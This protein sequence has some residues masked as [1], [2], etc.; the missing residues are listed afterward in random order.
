MH[1]R[2]GP[3][4]GA[5]V[6]STTRWLLSVSL[7]HRYMFYC[8]EKWRSKACDRGRIEQ[9][10]RVSPRLY[11]L[12]VKAQMWY[13]YQPECSFGTTFHE[14]WTTLTVQAAQK[15]STAM[16]NYNIKEAG[17]DARL[18]LSASCSS[19]SLPFKIF[20]SLRF[21]YPFENHLQLKGVTR[22]CT[23]KRRILSKH[24]VTTF[25]I[26]FRKPPTVEG[27]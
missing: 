8:G 3:G 13:L 21:R 2:A 6:I 18:H 14:Q 4:P 9:Y 12:C 10:T 19:S 1:G 22:K 11:D 5:L 20:K 16:S 15:S 27:G 7:L 26:P 23:L 25:R 24:T 17:D